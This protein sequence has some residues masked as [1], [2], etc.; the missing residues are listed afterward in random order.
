MIESLD[1]IKAN[2]IE[3]FLNRETEKWACPKCGGKQR[4]T[5]IIRRYTKNSINPKTSPHSSKCLG[6]PISSKHI[7]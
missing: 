2:R 7:F 3:Q 6:C 1:Y 4:I 5:L